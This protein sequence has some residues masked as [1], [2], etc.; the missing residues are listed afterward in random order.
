MSKTKVIRLSVKIICILFCCC[1]IN[2]IAQNKAPSDATGD[3]YLPKVNLMAKMIL[4]KTY[5]RDVGGSTFIP[6]P[7]PGMCPHGG[8]LIIVPVTTDHVYQTIS[9]NVI[10]RHSH[11][12]RVNIRE[13]EG[14]WL[15][16]TSDSK[17]IAPHE[18]YKVYC[19]YPPHQT[20]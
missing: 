17:S 16:T 5:E 2:A 19:Y 18:I 9:L 11:S 8:K 12:L 6:K 13:V 3:N 4:L 1:C 15:A 7:Q 14:G 20:S 10:R